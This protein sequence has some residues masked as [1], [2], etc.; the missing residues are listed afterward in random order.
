MRIRSL[1]FLLTEAFIILILACCEKEEE[2]GKIIN[3]DPADY[4]WDTST[5]VQVT[6]NGTSYITEDGEPNAALFS[7][8]YLS[9]FGQGS[10]EITAKYNDGI[11]SD[12]ELIIKNGNISVTAADDGIR[13][14]DY[15]IISSG[16]FTINVKGD[17]LKSDN[18]D[19][20]TLG[21]IVIDSA[22]ANITASGDGIAA[23]TKLTITDGYFNIKSGGGAPSTIS[24]GGTGGFQPPGGGRTSGG[25][26]GTVSAKALKALSSLKIENGTFIL[27]ST[28]DAIHSNNEVIIEGG[29]FKIATGPNSGNMIEVPSSASSQYSVKVTIASRLSSSTLFHIEDASGNDLVTFKP[30]RSVYY[31]VF[32][33]SA[34]VSGSTYSI[35]TGGSSTG[36]Y[37]DGIYTGGT[38]SG[39][40]LKKT[41]TISAK[42]TSVSI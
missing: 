18:E 42:I 15:L 22:T 11:S 12:D 30:V 6:L 20:N 31:L 34:L 21:F 35:Y 14:K 7:N 40:T 28:D 25:Y 26:T 29:N 23:Q 16:Y 39:G 24:T 36:T 13:G 9:I 38:Y 1:L 4:L 8:T 17:G 5:V 33:S 19:D 3:E 27:S 32:S 2:P 41:F 37:S 10:L